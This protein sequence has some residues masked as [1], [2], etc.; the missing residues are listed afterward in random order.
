M[1]RS[2]VVAAAASSAA[3]FAAAAVGCS[4]TTFRDRVA[5]DANAPVADASDAAS[6]VDVM[7][8]SDAAAPPGAIACGG[9]SCDVATHTCCIPAQPAKSLGD[10]FA[11]AASAGK[12]V[13]F[14]QCL[15]PS[16]SIRC[17]SVTCGDADGGAPICCVSNAGSAFTRAACLPLSACDSS[18][19]NDILCDPL[20][21]RCP[22]DHP[23][24]MPYRGEVDFTP[25]AICR[26]P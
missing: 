3:M 8:T 21:P 13:P 12:C 19:P 6:L 11:A 5:T 24:C 22:P 2:F 4:A 18:L 10:V 14:A 15:A 16:V 17:N 9:A 26:L 7:A 25:F 23:R 1:R 20:A